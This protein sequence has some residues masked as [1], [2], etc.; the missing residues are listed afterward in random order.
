MLA[1][2]RELYQR[3]VAYDD[4]ELLRIL[5]VERAQYRSEALAAAELVL[6][7]RGVA[8]PTFFHAPGPTAVVAPPA[9]PQGRGAG[10]GSPYELPDLCVDALFFLIAAWGWKKLWDW[11]EAPNWGGPLG[12]VAYWV[13]TFAFLCSIYSLRRKWRAKEW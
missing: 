5:T 10:P 4:E 11:T 2:E 7:H 12:S 6:M 1:G 13:L 9:A 3:F 8:P